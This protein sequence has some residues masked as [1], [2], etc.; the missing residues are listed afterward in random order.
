MYSAEWDGAASDAIIGRDRGYP[1]SVPEHG[2]AGAVRAACVGV[3]EHA[4]HLLYLGNKE[5]CG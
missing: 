2:A 3:L 4:L 5:G 1:M